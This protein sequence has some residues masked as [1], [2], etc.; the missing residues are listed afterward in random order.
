VRQTPLTP[1]LAAKLA[2]LFPGEDRSLAQQWLVSEIDDDLPGGISNSMALLERIRA[3]ALKFS[4]GSLDRLARA[5]SLAQED[6]RDVLL[7]AGF[8]DARAHDEW[9]NE[10]LSN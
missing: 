3:A 4:G 10:P 6:W 8:G 2:A 5:T 9:L 7:A 1:R